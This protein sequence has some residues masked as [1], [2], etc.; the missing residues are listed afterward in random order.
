MQKGDKIL[1]VSW[2]SHC[3]PT[4]HECEIVS[5]ENYFNSPNKK[6]NFFFENSKQIE[7]INSDNKDGKPT[8]G[9]I[10]HFSYFDNKEKAL[11]YLN[12]RIRS[13]KWVYEQSMNHWN[14]QLE[15][16]KTIV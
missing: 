2:T 3:S 16:L 12:D 9:H 4:L 5:V 8:L 7:T 1:I 13:S 6:I 11:E 14:K 15:K 10:V